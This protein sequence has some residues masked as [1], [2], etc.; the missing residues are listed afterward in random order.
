MYGVP[1]DLDLSFLQGAEVIQVC[2]GLH[3]V[4]FH[5]HPA[6]SVHVQGGWELVGAEGGRIDHGHDRPEQR[7]PYQIHRLLGRRVAGTEVSPP[8]WISLRFDD[9]AVLRIFDD[10]REHESFQI[11]PG[12]IVV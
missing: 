11:Q 4:Q 5:F 12:D 3:E 10:S 1:T 8:A 6:G 2:L 9:G 7:P